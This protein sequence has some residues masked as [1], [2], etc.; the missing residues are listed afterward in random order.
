MV[1]LNPYEGST[2]GAVLTGWWKLNNNWYYF[3]KE[4]DGT[5]GAMLINTVTPDGQHVG[6]DG[7]WLGY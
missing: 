3:N 2:Q 7:V 1:S 5:Y 6:S 4:H